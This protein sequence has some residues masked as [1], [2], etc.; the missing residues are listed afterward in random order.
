MLWHVWQE[1]ELLGRLRVTSLLFALL[2][3]ACA[4]NPL[5]DN[6]AGPTAV[7]NESIVSKAGQSVDMFYVAA[8]NGK[9][10][11]NS[12]IATAMNSSGRGPV[13]YSSI[14]GR[15][16]PVEPL[17][18]S[19]VGERYYAAPIIAMF[20][21]TYHISGDIAFTPQAGAVYRVRGELLPLSMSVWVEET[22]T[23]RPVS[24]KLEVERKPPP[25][26]PQL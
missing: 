16:V 13:I 20:N 15:K 23:G 8:I 3:T 1:V 25:L 26:L 2:V 11:H 12:R 18:I 22:T 24:P 5:P 17:V 14:V 10:I 7:L 19:L 6:Y 21:E 9:R 4:G